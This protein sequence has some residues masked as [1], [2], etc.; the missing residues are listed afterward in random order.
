M[1]NLTKIFIV[2]L[3]F[4]ASLF[5][6]D[7]RAFRRLPYATNPNLLCNVCER[8][9]GDAPYLTLFANNQPDY[10]FQLLYEVASVWNEEGG[11]N[12]WFGVSMDSNLKIADDNISAVIMGDY[13]GA[14]Q[15]D[16]LGLSVPQPPSPLKTEPGLDPEGESYIAIVERDLLLCANQDWF[17][18]DEDDIGWW[19]YDL[20]SVILH[21][22]GHHLGLGHANCNGNIPDYN[23]TFEGD[24]GAVMDTAVLSWWWGDTRRHLLNQPFG[25][26]IA[27]GDVQGIQH[28]YGLYSPDLDGDGI[29]NLE[30]NCPKVAN[31]GQENNDG[32]FKGDACDNDDDNDGI[33][34]DIDS[35]PFEPQQFESDFDKD[36]IDDL[37]DPDDD[38]DGV[39]DN[40]D[41]CQYAVNK[42]QVDSDNDGKGDA[43]ETDDD[44]DGVHDLL[45]NCP[46]V[47]NKDQLDKDKDGI[48]DA[49][50]IINMTT[51]QLQAMI[52]AHNN[53]FGLTKEKLCAI[54]HAMNKFPEGCK[55]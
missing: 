33:K 25:N 14:C 50:D 18:G 43:C 19:D 40:I 10:L 4:V 51:E 9:P 53:R 21:E 2:I 28:I 35:C 22:L 29:A 32:D 47:Y 3:F 34:D 38:N 45:D 11:A 16:I 17:V 23:C 13:Y 20:F 42:N 36:G 31:Q 41:N 6:S 1:N 39:A 46:T 12:F 44:G 37:C 5:S 52:E 8:V 26:Y 49:C 24:T 55:D 30:D 54:A 15:E 48:G 7:I 27:Q